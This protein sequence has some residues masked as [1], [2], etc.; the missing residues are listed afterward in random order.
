[1]SVTQNTY[2]QLRGRIEKLVSCPNCTR[3]LYVEG[4]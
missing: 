4:S 3:I 1:M 2:V